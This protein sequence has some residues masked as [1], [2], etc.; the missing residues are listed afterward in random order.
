MSTETK[1]KKFQFRNVD[2]K[3]WPFM[4][5]ADAIAK[6]WAKKETGEPTKIY[7]HKLAQAQ[8]KKKGELIPKR[9]HKA[10]PEQ[11]H[12]GIDSPYDLRR[13]SGYKT[14]WQ[15]LAEN[16]NTVVSW[17]VLQNEVNERLKAEE[18]SVAWYE[19][20]FTSPHEKLEKEVDGKTVKYDGKLLPSC[21]YDT[22]YN[23]IVIAR[24]PYNGIL[25]D[26]TIKERSIEGMQ[27][28]VIISDD[29]ATLLTEVTEPRQIKSR[30]RNPIKAKVDV[31]AEI[32]AEVA[33]EL[34]EIVLDDDTSEVIE[35]PELV[36]E[37]IAEPEEEIEE[38]ELD[39]NELTEVPL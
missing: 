6:K 30:G 39:P 11:S 25:P 22:H 15:V 21:E 27:Q 14:I 13:R 24:A 16:A 28:R 2:N 31:V 7:F 20:N 5:L 23:A 37:V 10:I 9:A 4:K 1:E 18:I 26:G 3:G 33:T 36:A 19:K 32:V 17:D 34:N 38:E 29:G 8:A 12:A 35:S